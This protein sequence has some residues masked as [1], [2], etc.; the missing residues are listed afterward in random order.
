[1]N[2]FKVFNNRE[3][4]TM[5]NV[6]YGS[7]AVSSREGMS[8]FVDSHANLALG[9]TIHFKSGSNCSWH[10]SGNNPYAAFKDFKGSFTVNKSADSI[11]SLYEG[12]SFVDIISGTYT[13]TSIDKTTT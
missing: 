5:T 8:S 13:K 6:D 2:A 11:I 9:T 4:Y 10:F 12:D 3:C 1:M 7:A